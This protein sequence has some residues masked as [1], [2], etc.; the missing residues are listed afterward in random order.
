M[1]AETILGVAQL[2]IRPSTYRPRPSSAGPE[3]CL[4]QLVYKGRGVPEPPPGRRL[5]M[6]FRDGHAH[7]DTSLEFL[8]DSAFLMHSQQLPID[9]DNAYWWRGDKP[10]YRCPDCSRAAG[11]DVWIPPTRLHGHIDALA[12]TILGDTYLFEHKAVVSHFFRRYWEEGKT[13]LDYFTQV[14]M[15]LRGLKEKGIVITAGAL[16]IKNKD[17]GAILEFEFSYTHEPDMLTITAIIKAPGHEYKPVC[18][19]YPGLY[20][21]ALRRFEEVDRH[22]TNRTLPPRLESSDDIRCEYCGHRDLCWEDYEAP[23]LTERLIIPE[24]LKAQAE[25]FIELDDRLAPLKKRHKDLKDTIKAEFGHLHIAQ[26]YVGDRILALATV[27]QT[28]LDESRLPVMLK[29][30]FSETVPTYKLSIKSAI[31]KARTSKA[32]KRPNVPRGPHTDAA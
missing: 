6:I 13:P 16:V 22:I 17:T 14:V 30:H 7:E 25:E 19:Q 21:Q 18:H 26:A 10:S 32:A 12:T 5:A 29:K 11:H 23:T 9:I 2:G 27:M 1:F 28:R 8:K 4:R 3:R 15:Y 31:P 24:T 20:E